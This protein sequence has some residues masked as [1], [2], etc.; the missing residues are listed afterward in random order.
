MTQQI[1][2]VTWMLKI[3]SIIK[4]LDI[5]NQTRSEQREK[6]MQHKES[7]RKL[8]MSFKLANSLTLDVLDHLHVYFHVDFQGTLKLR[9][10]QH[11]VLDGN[12]FTRIPSLQ[13]SIISQSYI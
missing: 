1:L 4:M 5:H 2:L 10:L 7:Q 6:V 12:S 3:E 8:G 13:G 11:L 9:K